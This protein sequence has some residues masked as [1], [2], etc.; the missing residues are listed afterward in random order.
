M[1]VG[2]FIYIQCIYHEYIHDDGVLHSFSQYIMN[3]CM[4][5]V[6]YIYAQCVPYCVTSIHT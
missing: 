2:G 1:N 3:I 5:V 4:W 6:Y